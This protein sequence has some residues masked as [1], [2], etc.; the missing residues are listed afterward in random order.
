MFGNHRFA[1]VVGMWPYD[2][3][4]ID[5]L[6]IRSL[7]TKHG[8]SPLRRCFLTSMQKPGEAKMIC[9]TDGPGLLTPTSDIEPNDTACTHASRATL[10]KLIE[11]QGYKCALTGTPL[12]P[13]T[14]SIDHIIPM[15]DGGKNYIE[16]LEVVRC[17]VNA[18]KGTMS[19]DAFVK[20]CCE[21][22]DWSRRGE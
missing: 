3:R 5:A 6:T 20:M 14:A 22:A 2:R 10:R 21:V 8:K 15:A 18:A 9:G 1:A 19:R 4:T 11:D 12:T 13:P 16:N 17:D 7:A